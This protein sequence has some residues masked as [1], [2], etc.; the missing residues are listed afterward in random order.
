M[1][2]GAFNSAVAQNFRSGT[3]EPQYAGVVGGDGSYYGAGGAAGHDVPLQQVQRE[4]SGYGQSRREVSGTQRNFGPEQL[5]ARFC[6]NT[7][8]S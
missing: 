2:K 1:R 7:H 8:S 6:P 4:E 3:M 5:R